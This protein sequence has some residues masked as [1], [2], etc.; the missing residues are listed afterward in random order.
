[1]V[2]A[3]PGPLI[4]AAEAC[5]MAGPGGRRAE[6]TVSSHSVPQPGKRLT[7]SGG[8]GEGALS[9]GSRPHTSPVFFVGRLAIVLV[10]RLVAFWSDWWR[11][12]ERV[13]EHSLADTVLDRAYGDPC[14]RIEQRELL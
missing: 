7:R 5:W 9:E 13:G 1:M 12:R 10:W 11:Q 14:D 2:G 6:C 4:V 3:M 8:E